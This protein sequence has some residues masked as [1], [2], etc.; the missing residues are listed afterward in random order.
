M[1]PQGHD[2]FAVD[3]VKRST[4]RDLRCSAQ[5]VRD[6]LPAGALALNIRRD[7]MNIAEYA[8]RPFLQP[9]AFF[10]WKFVRTNDSAR[11]RREPCDRAR[12]PD[13]RL[14]EEMRVI[15]AQSIAQNADELVVAIDKAFAVDLERFV[16][17]ARS[18][19]QALRHERPLFADRAA[20]L[21]HR[22][23]TRENRP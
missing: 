21:S 11:E 1:A 23:C 12:C 2:G 10:R 6:H 18:F 9:L 22:A 16:F 20:R 4:R 14:R 3:A 13:T 15:L 17:S 19:C 5:H 7:A 8:L